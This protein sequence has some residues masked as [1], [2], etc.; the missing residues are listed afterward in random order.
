M[1]INSLDFSVFR[2]QT[3]CGRDTPQDL[4]ISITNLTQGL[5]FTPLIVAAHN[6]DASIFSVATTASSELQMMAGGGD[7]S[8]LG[9]APRHHANGRQC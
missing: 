7:V 6:G 1:R 9:Q 8:G 5:H 2:P 3:P 4:N